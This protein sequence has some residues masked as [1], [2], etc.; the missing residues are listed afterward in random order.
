MTASCACT[1][2]AALCPSSPSSTNDTVCGRVFKF[3][4]VLQRD[5]GVEGWHLCA[6]QVVMP[7]V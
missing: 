6:T 1:S 4:F 2:E 5:S 7:K 3:K